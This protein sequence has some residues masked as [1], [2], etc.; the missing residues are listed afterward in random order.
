VGRAQTSSEVRV[1]GV[2]AWSERFEIDRIILRRKFES[3]GDDA[4]RR[5]ARVRPG[6]RV[7]EPTT[8]APGIRGVK[9]PSPARMMPAPPLRHFAPLERSERGPH[10]LGRIIS[11]MSEA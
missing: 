11:Y 3:V 1:D 6:W 2:A 10:L 8:E 4:S 9:S 5:S 7:A